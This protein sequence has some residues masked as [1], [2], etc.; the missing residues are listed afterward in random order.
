MPSLLRRLEYYL[1]EGGVNCNELAE[2]NPDWNL[3]KTM[4]KTGVRRLRHARPDETTLDMAAQAATRVLD[5]LDP[6][7]TPDTVI[8]VTQTPDMLL[9]QCSAL[10]QHRLGLDRSVKCLDVSHGCSGYAYGLATAY[11]FLRSGLS[12]RVLLVTADN[13]SKIIDPQDKKTYLLFSDGASA[14][15]LEDCGQEVAFH[16]GTEG[17][18]GPSIVCRNSGIGVATGEAAGRPIEPPRFEMDG[19]GV[20]LFTLGRIPSE[21]MAFLERAGVGWDDVD[22]VVPHQASR[23]VLESIRAKLNIPKEKFVIDLEEVGNTTSSSIPIAMKRAEQAGR[24]KHGDTVLL[25]GFGIG[26]SWGGALLTY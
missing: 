14:S 3:G 23:F 5:G 12:R 1:P 18:L 2:A 16:F 21:I 7:Q 19:Y 26:L 15:L 10:L 8:V 4:A 17:S 22:L 24:L 25:F 13:Y 6:D 11:G 9:P 20:F